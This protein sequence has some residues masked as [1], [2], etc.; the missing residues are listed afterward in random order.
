MYSHL[1]YA[2]HVWGSASKRDLDKLLILQKK[3]VRMMTFKD[4]YPSIPSRRNPSNPLFKQLGILKIQDIYK[5]NFACFIYDT[6]K[7]KTPINFA[8]WFKYNHTIHSYNTR[9]NTN[10]VMINDSEIE[11]TNILHIQ[12]CN[13][14]TYGAKT[15]KVA[16]RVLWNELLDQIRNANSRFIF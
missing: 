15:F 2:V 12:N 13:L 6:L 14:S 7:Q 16:G 11:L 10:V 3:A 8:E 1:S 9:A 4:R 5:L